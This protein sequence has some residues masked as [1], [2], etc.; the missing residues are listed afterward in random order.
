MIV[1]GSRPTVNPYLIWEEIER[2]EAEF[3]HVSD[4]NNM[5]FRTLRAR[6]ERRLEKDAPP[7]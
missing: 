3:D 7:V 1:L 5:C 2:L 4:C 6:I